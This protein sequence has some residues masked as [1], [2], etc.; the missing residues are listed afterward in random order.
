MEPWRRLTRRPKALPALLAGAIALASVCGYAV[1]RGAVQPSDEEEIHAATAAASAVD[2]QLQSDSAVLAAAGTTIDALTSFGGYDALVGADL[3]GVIGVIAHP[4]VATISVV[5]ATDRALADRYAGADVRKPEWQILFGLARDGGGL[6]VTADNNLVV[7]ARAVYGATVPASV[8]ERRAVVQ[9]YVVLLR[10]VSVLDRLLEGL[11]SGGMDV[12]LLQDRRAVAGAAN[13]PGDAQVATRATN[14]GVWSVQAWSTST[15]SKAPLVVLLGGLV[16]A[17]GVGVAFSATQRATTAEARDAVSRAEELRLV[18]RM[19]PLLQQSLD[20]AD[21]LPLF[22]VEVSEQLDLDDITVSIVSPSGEL[23]KAFSVGRGTPVP[24]DGIPVLAPGSAVPPGTAVGIPLQRG[25]RVIG[26][27]SGTARS[28]LAASQVDALRAVGDLLAA[29]LGNAA[30]LLEEQELVAKLRDVD[31]LKATFLGAVSHELRTM[32]IAIQGFAD[33]LIR[34]GGQLDETRRNDF[35]DRIVRNA[36]SL[37]VLVEDLLDFARLESA[38]ISVTLQPVDLSEL[39]PKVV[40]QMTSIVGDRAV[41]V[42]IEDAVVAMADPSA[43]E[44]ILV[45]LLSNA[46]KYT[47]IGSTVRVSVGRG[48]GEALLTVADDGP[49][50]DAVERERI[51][52]LFYRVD[53]DAARAARGVGI[54]LAL[55]RQLAELLNGEI[56]AADTPGG[57]ATF[58]LTIPIAEEDAPSVAPVRRDAHVQAS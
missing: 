21:I 30:V 49:G 50:I 16:M 14:G 32:V 12:R 4:P 29:A 9:G 31:R 15:S 57:G 2:A 19:G 18:A 11:G 20:V 8:A 10:P 52:D 39:V 43:I 17:L 3:A 1:T 55:V 51:F 35:V 22:V 44:R 6:T 58:R 54:G 25:G 37:G 47:P 53:N 41:F 38:G 27:L 33:L 45:N 46:A 13:G 24:S 56:I 48:D 7:E 36:R 42:D 34:Q 23:T 5:E 40:E 28:G 26:V